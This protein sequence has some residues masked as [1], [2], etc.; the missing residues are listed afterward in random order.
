MAS[1]CPATSLKLTPVDFSTYTLAVDLPT[2]IPMLPPIFFE[3][4]AKSTHS[5]ISGTIKLNIL[6]IH[7]DVLSGIA[8]FIS[9][10]LP[11]EVFAFLSVGTSSS[12]ATRPV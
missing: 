1:S 10:D 4:N 2:P 12:S 7:V 3:I 5:K 9:I 11:S 8:A 6:K